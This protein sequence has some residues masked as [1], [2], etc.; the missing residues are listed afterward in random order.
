MI[1]F[2]QFLYVAFVVLLLFNITIFI[3]ELGHYLVGRWRGA[4]IERFA[5]W[6][7]PALWS[8]TINGVEFRLGCIPLGGYVAFPQLAMEAIEGKSQTPSEELKPLP[9]RD[10]IPILFAGSFSNVLLG[11]VI[12]TLV[13]ILGI[14]KDPSELNL[15]IGYVSPDSPEY[16]AGIRPG[17]QIV[18][19][20]S[21]PVKEWSE[22]IQQV[23]LSK[24][25]TV[26]VGLERNGKLEDAL[27]IPRKD[28][29]LFDLRKL[30]LGPQQTPVASEIYPG[31]PAEAAGLKAGDQFLEINGEKILSLAH[32]TQIIRNHP[33]EPISIK[34]RRNGNE[35]TLTVTPKMASV[36][37]VKS[38]KIGAGLD[39]LHEGKS[40][41]VHP[42]PLFQITRSLIM[43]IDT[44]NALFHSKTTGVGID[45]LS[46][47]VG[48]SVLL[49]RTL[50]ADFRLALSFVVLLNIN[51]AV[52]NLLPIPVLDGGHIVFS[53]IEAIRR[54]PLN[55]RM[56]ETVQTVFVA[57][58]I[59]FMIYVTIN[60]IYRFFPSKKADVRETPVFEETTPKK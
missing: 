37:N 56:L 46:G 11:F 40:V 51:L 24:S 20:N 50:L 54:K 5:I 1:G 27:V 16:K 36:K 35:E 43:M 29:A 3:H 26:H 45:D 55:Q 21:K 19:I 41:T 32:M 44:V 23:A 60:D 14:P 47:P 57:L 4:K 17:D 9:P 58:L 25:E 10:K 2:L 39:Y 49:Y 18:S 13:W 7:G 12:A 8:K 30:N 59:T 53:I 33:D 15:K 34:I 38:A 31:T 48:I 6:F 42:T 52:I 28:D 22:I